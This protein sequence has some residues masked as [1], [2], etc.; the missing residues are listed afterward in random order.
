MAIETIPFR[1]IEKQTKDICEATVVMAKRARQV[2]ADRMAK[3]E[4]EEV[5]EEPGLLEEEPEILEDYEEEE[6]ATSVALTE[7]LK[8]ELRWSYSSVE[9]EP[10]DTDSEKE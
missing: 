7:F 4:I 1:E 5:E 3:R 8:D 10:A 9:G 2:V 6:K